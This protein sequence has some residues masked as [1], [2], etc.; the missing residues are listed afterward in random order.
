MSYVSP[1][2]AKHLLKILG[3]NVRVLSVSLF[4]IDHIARVHSVQV[5]HPGATWDNPKMRFQIAVVDAELWD[6]E[7][8]A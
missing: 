8:E 4:L 3:D 1:T 5:K 2:E 6:R 7:K